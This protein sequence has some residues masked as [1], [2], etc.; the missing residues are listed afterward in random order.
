[1]DENRIESEIIDVEKVVEINKSIKEEQAKI[2][3]EQMSE[4]F[5][6][7]TNSEGFLVGLTTLNNGELKHYLIVNK[8]PESDMLKASK[9][10]KNL[11]IQKLEG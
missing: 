9:E 1:M 11:I 4:L 10:I 2:T 5:S 3:K 7:A 8:F 6:A